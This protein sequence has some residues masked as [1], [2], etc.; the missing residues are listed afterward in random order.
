MKRNKKEE[1]FNEVTQLLRG[2][3]NK[4]RNDQ[5]AFDS[6]F[7]SDLDLLFTTSNWGFRELTLVIAIARLLNRNYKASEAFYIVIHDLYLNNRFAIFYLRIIFL[8][9]NRDP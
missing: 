6:V 8:I 3:V 9:E 7:S 4:A 5:L 1:R 2:I